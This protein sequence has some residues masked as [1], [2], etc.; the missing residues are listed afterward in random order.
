M[1]MRNKHVFDTLDPARRQRRDI[2]KIEQDCTSLEQGLKAQDWIAELSV[3]EA[4]M[5][6][7]AHHIARALEGRVLSGPRLRFCGPSNAQDANAVG[8]AIF[9]RKK[10]MKRPPTAPSM[11]R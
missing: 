10:L 8:S 1:G 5:D 7:R 11:T 2:A 3:D 4:G 6:K 9:S